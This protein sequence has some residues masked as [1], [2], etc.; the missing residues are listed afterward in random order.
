MGW[1]LPGGHGRKF[2]STSQFLPKKEK[3]KRK[4]KKEKKRQMRKST[5]KTASYKVLR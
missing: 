5:V 2:A 1:E 3:K 4:K